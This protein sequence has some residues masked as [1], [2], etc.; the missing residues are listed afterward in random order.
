MWIQAAALTSL[1]LTLGLAHAPAPL[2]APVRG[3]IDASVDGIRPTMAGLR[4]Q[5][6]GSSEGGL[7][8]AL[9]VQVLKPFRGPDLDVALEI[10]TPDGVA[11]LGGSVTA[12]GDTHQRQISGNDLTL[13]GGTGAYENASGALRA[14][15]TADTRARLISIEYEGRICS[16]DNELIRARAGRQS[17]LDA[18]N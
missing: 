9:K 15:G 3:H 12:Q 11:S 8:G 17:R 6:R 7:A 16:A 13:R 10:V 18:R 4:L 2:C 14:R 5:G 1:T